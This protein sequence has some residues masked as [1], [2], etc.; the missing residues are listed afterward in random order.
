M[1]H[2]KKPLTFMV[3][4]GLLFSTTAFAKDDLSLME[5]S[6]LTGDWGG[7]R[8]KLKENGVDI[9]YIHTAEDMKENAVVVSLRTNIKF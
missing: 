4:A 8:T 7:T 9:Q 5:R 6:Y 2:L 3:L 1:R